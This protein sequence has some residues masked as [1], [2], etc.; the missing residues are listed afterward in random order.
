MQIPTAGASVTLVQPTIEDNNKPNLYR[1]EL[2]ARAT[3]N[4]KPK[5]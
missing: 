2:E 5:A 3:D 1:H 4:C